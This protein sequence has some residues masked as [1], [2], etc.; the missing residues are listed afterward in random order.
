MRST[1]K[2]CGAIQS[3]AQP[4]LLDTE[5]CRA[6]RIVVRI[7]VVCL[8]L[9]LGRNGLMMSSISYI[10]AGNLGF[11]LAVLWAA[12]RWPGRWKMLAWLVLGSFLINVFD[13]V[14]HG[15]EDARMALLM[16]PLLVLYGALL[17]EFTMG[18][19][20]LAAVLGIYSWAWLRRNPIGQGEALD[21][22]SLA[23]TSVVSGLA[24]LG[25]WLQYRKAAQA[26]VTQAANLRREL[27][28]NARLTG[29]IS[30]DLVNPLSAVLG[31]VDIAQ[32]RGGATPAQLH[33]IEKM[34]RRIQQ[35]VES[36]RAMASG[37]VENLPLE[38]IPM[39]TLCHDL[40]QIFAQR[41]RE[42]NQQLLATE[43]MDLMVSSNAQFLCNSVLSNILSNAIKFTP[44]N[45]A[46]ELRASLQGDRVV[47]GFLDKGPGFPTERI[48]DVLR[49][50]GCPS[51]VGTDGEPGSGAGLRIAAFYAEHLKGHLVIDRPATGGSMVAVSLPAYSPARKSEPPVSSPANQRHVSALSEA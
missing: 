29:V 12:G 27:E 9:V 43:G 22:A 13:K 2:N 5:Q 38:P 3:T 25:V 37:A 32:K 23:I 45:E 50:K 24:G 17:G 8:A 41:L 18:G 15:G 51:Q 35:I 19:V 49:G 33:D 39:A 7:G 10:D 4:A 36:A 21:I 48:G 44:R 11:L 47:I 30:H 1:V 14:G 20:T 16:L 46:I 6:F 31:L 42:K 28:V 26:L 40:Q 34:A